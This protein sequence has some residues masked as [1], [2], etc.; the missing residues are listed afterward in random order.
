MCIV[1]WSV[2]TLST[3]WADDASVSGKFTGNGKPSKLA[4][5]SASKA[6]E[7]SGKPTI[8]IIM[9]EQDHSKEKRAEMKAAFGD[10]GSALLITVFEDGKVCGCEVAHSAHKM[11]F[12]ALG[13]IATSDFKIADGMISGKLATKGEVEAFKQK[14]EVQLAFKVKAP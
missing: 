5:I 3:A 14:W 10:F 12:S 1:S 4:F 9:T 13:D 6:G 2:L 7:L 8:R 11:P